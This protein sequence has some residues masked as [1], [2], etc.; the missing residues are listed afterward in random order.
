MNK[1]FTN[2]K[3]LTRLCVAKI[4]VL[5]HEHLSMPHMVAAETEDRDN[6]SRSPVQ[7][8]AHKTQ[9]HFNHEA[10]SLCYVGTVSGSNKADKGY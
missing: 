7:I 9:F 3:V 8:A 5:K 2:Q 6:R 4:V 10:T 1:N